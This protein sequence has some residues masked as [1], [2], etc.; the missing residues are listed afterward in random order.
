M[1]PGLLRMEVVLAKATGW[2]LKHREALGIGFVLVILLALAL[3]SVSSIRSAVQIGGDEHFEVSKGL[4]WAQGHRLYESVWNDQPP[5]HTIL[6]GTLFKC[7]GPG[8]GAARGLAAFFGVLLVMACYFLVKKRC[9]LLAALVATVSL[10]TA[11]QVFE[12]SVSVMLE[13]PAISL[14][15]WALWPL[16]RWLENPRQH[17]LITSALL[18]AAA[19]QVK[20]TAAIVIPAM[21]VEIALKSNDTAQK[22]RVRLILTNLSIWAGV[23]FLGWFAFGL[24]MGS[25]YD[26]AWTSHFSA[27]S[28]QSREAQS[29]AFSPNLIVRHADAFWGASAALVIASLRRDWRRIAFPMVLFITVMCIHLKHRPW[30]NYYY[31]HFAVPLSWLTGYALAELFR[32]ACGERVIGRF[33]PIFIRLVTLVAGSLLLSAIVAFGGVRLVSA[34]ERIRDLPRIKD[35]AIIEIMTQNANQVK[36]VY[37]E[38]TIHPFHAK[39]RV[40]P[41]LAVMPAKRFWSGQITREQILRVL[42]R[43]QPEL[44]LFN[45]EPLALE[46]KRFIDEGYSKAFQNDEHILYVVRSLGESN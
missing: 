16:F 27:H 1:F 25:R 38:S 46:M 44:I 36:W 40:I 2:V 18:L 32:V 22:S 31:L 26:D 37:A 30:W 13:V 43:Y 14:A 28:T 6:L 3:V 5:L 8:I 24:V 35:S 39:L 17:L 15:L 41:E 23:I 21:A 42:Q 34:V 20:L 45:N 10:L 4:L 19:L 33:R 11:P 12:L 9:G 29:L 7:F